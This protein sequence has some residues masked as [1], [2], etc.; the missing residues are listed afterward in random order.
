MACWHVG[1]C[2]VGCEPF[3]PAVNPGMDI[4]TGAPPACGCA[5][6]IQELH[7]QIIQANEQNG[8]LYVLLGAAQDRCDRLLEKLE[9]KGR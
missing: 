8:R 7:R 5:P 6:L 4:P 1:P 9:S 2:G 3:A